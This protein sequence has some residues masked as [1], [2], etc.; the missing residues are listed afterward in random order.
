MRYFLDSTVAIDYLRGLPASIERLSGM[1]ASGD[2][3][4]IN[5]VVICELATG[6]RTDEEHGLA[7]FISALEFVQPSPDV[8]RLAGRWRGSARRRGETLSVPDALIA[9]T[10][11]ALGAILVTRN[12]HDFE[13]TPVVVEAY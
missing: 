5:D 13:L 6:V 12:A 4:F 11:E 3:A 1:F 10:A 7:S 2:R 9:A 8:A